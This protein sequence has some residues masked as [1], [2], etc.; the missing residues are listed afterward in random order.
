MA[1]FEDRLSLNRR[2]D[3]WSSVEHWSFMISSWPYDMSALK[4]NCAV[5]IFMPY[6]RFNYRYSHLSTISPNG[7]RRE[8][9]AGSCSTCAGREHS[10][11][12]GLSGRLSY[13]HQHN[14]KGIVQIPLFIYHS[15][16]TRIR[17]TFS[18][19]TIVRCLEFFSVR[20]MN[21]LV[22]IEPCLVVIAYITNP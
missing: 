19:H 21:F 1:E 6:Y 12:Y 14:A 20:P 13:L 16:S 11:W 18:I 4:N 17:F 5:I 10:S 3:H 9:T 2:D 7:T 15:R 22:L 8:S